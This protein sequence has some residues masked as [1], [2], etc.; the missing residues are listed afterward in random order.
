MEVNAKQKLFSTFEPCDV[1]LLFIV[2]L[3]LY[4]YTEFYTDD[5]Q[6]Y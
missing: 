2:Q 1:D 5:F 4:V 6:L 3:F